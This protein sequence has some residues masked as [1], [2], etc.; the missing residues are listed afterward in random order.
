MKD[1]SARN[2]ELGAAGGW[3]PRIQR[4]QAGPPTRLGD[5]AT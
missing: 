4:W 1:L 2:A 5:P 3:L